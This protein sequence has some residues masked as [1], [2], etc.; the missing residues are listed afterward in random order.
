MSTTKK[1][2]VKKEVPNSFDSWEEYYFNEWLKELGN[3]N[4]I[5]GYSKC[6]TPF[7]ISE[8]VTVC[9]AGKKK[10]SN[11]TILKKLTYTPD[12]IASFNYRSMLLTASYGIKNNYPPEA[13]FLNNLYAS[14]N[15]ALYFEVKGAYTKHLNSSITFRDR[16]AMLYASQD[17]YVNKV[18]PYSLNTKYTKTLFELTFCP[19]KFID[20]MVYTKGEKKGQSKIPFLIK[21]ISQFNEE[22]KQHQTKYANNTTN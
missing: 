1:T 2:V 22:F 20:D 10:E 16:Q 3:Y 15:Y 18:I 12:Y 7:I 5:S 13:Y 17:I 4:I 14:Q 21:T 8:K 9:F 19:Q 11:K 6:R